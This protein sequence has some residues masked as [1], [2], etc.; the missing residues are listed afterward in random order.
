MLMNAFLVMTE[1]MT[2]ERT[3]D[4]WRGEF[5]GPVTVTAEARSIEV[6]RRSL[7]EALDAKVAAWLSEASPVRSTK[8]RSRSA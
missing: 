5:R 6:C 4:G 2:Y 1:R 7:I 8:R 3:T